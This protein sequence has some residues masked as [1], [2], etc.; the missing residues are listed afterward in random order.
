LKGR[1]DSG[2]PVLIFFAA[3]PSTRRSCSAC[4][5]PSSPFPASILACRVRPAS[6][7]R[8]RAGFAR[9]S[10]DG[11]GRSVRL[12]TRNGHDLADRLPLA[13]EAI[14]ALP[15]RSCVADGEVIV[16]DDSGLA[17]LD[18]MDRQRVA[19]DSLCRRSAAAEPL[20]WTFTVTRTS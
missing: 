10:T 7:R 17:V 12:I 16:C 1:L 11:R 14:E 9:S 15:V 6:R 19:A 4:C 8:V 13:A 2:A 18:L 3:M 20:K 5:A